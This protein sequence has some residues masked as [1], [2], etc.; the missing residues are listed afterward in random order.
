MRERRKYKLGIRAIRREVAICKEQSQGRTGRIRRTHR[1]YRI[2]C[3][4]VA[5]RTGG[6]RR[7]VAPFHGSTRS[8]ESL[9]HHSL[10]RITRSSLAIHPQVGK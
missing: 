6:P 9:A 4:G 2:G 1:M 3:R 5:R 10:L 8:Y 7:G